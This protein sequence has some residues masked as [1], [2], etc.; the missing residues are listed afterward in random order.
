MDETDLAAFAEVI[1]AAKRQFDASDSP[2][3][4]PVKREE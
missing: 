2:P 4:Q 3:A 1:A